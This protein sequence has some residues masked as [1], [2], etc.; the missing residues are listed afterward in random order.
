MRSVSRY[1]GMPGRLAW[2]GRRHPDEIYDVILFGKRPPMSF[3]RFIGDRPVSSSICQETC[4]RPP[5]GAS[6]H[7]ERSVDLGA[8]AWANLSASF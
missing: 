4:T 3:G 8:W 5:Q 2:H 1:R 6:N 7:D